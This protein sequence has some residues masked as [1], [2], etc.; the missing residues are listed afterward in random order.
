MSGR[1]LKLQALA[2]AIACASN[3]RILSEYMQQVQ[4]TATVVGTRPVSRAARVI[5]VCAPIALSVT[6]H[7]PLGD[8]VC[9][10]VR[11]LFYHIDSASLICSSETRTMDGATGPQG[12]H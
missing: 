2:K 7:E 10:C 11:C 5:T 8:E 3:L 12:F 9:V 4:P 1:K 6:L